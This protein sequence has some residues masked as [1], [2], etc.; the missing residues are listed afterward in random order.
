MKIWRHRIV[1]NM[2]IW[3][4]LPWILRAE[5]F[6]F[7][8]Q[9]RLHIFIQKFPDLYSKEGT[10]NFGNLTYLTQLIFQVILMKYLPWMVQ[11]IR[12]LKFF[13]IFPKN[14]STDLGSL[15]DKLICNLEI[16]LSE[17][18]LSKTVVSWY[19]DSIGFGVVT[20]ELKN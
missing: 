3:K 19:Y 6:K 8:G 12:F 15:K 13:S 20:S 9:W 7:F 2:K 17:S 1:Q 16:M 10:Q 5:F 4:I 11:S 18:K 14:D